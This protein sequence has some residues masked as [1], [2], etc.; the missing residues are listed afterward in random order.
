GVIEYAGGPVLEHP[1]LRA[2]SGQNFIGLGQRHARAD[3]QR[4]GAEAVDDSQNDCLEEAAQRSDFR[5]IHALPQETELPCNAKVDVAAPT[6]LQQ[7][8]VAALDRSNPR[9]L[10][11]EVAIYQ[12]A[13]GR[14]REQESNPFCRAESILRGRGS[15]AARLRSVCPQGSAVPEIRTD[16]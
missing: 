1:E 3:G 2:Q 13:P 12:R 5:G 16:G 4:T 11:F 9:F 14:R 15:V 10:L 7:R 8:S 6:G